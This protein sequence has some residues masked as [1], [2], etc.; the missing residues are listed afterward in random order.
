MAGPLQP[1]QPDDLAAR[2]G[3]R[4]VPEPSRHGHGGEGDRGYAVNREESE[5]GVSAVAAPILDRR[6]RAIAAISITGHVCRL[7]LDRLAPAVRT[8]ARALSRELAR[9]GP[10]ELKTGTPR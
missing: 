10:G 5:A 3:E 2:D 7:D 6:R 9:E 4:H 8:A 1:G